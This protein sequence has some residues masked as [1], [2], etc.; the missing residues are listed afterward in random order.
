MLVNLCGHDHET[1]YVSL[2]QQH[3]LDD[4]ATAYEDA[5]KLYSPLPLY[6][7][8]YSTGALAISG[9]VAQSQGKP[10]QAGVFLAPAFALT[11]RAQLVRLL[12]PLRFLQLRLPSLAPRQLRAHHSTSLHAY[13]AMYS[14]WQGLRSATGTSYLNQI[15]V[16]IYANPDDELVSFHGLKQWLAKHNL[17]N[18]QLTGVEGSF[19]YQH[20]LIDGDS[21]IQPTWEDMIHNVVECYNCAS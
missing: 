19:D 12:T 20:L 16:L 10:F 2:T 8:A 9:F 7:V 17:N 4:I 11:W 21:W 15:P 13:H 6:F 14:L 5:Q 3:W 18:W 1:K